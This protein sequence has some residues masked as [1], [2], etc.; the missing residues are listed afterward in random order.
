[1]LGGHPQ[2]ISLAAPM[3][4][5]QNLID[6]FKQLL[7]SNIMDALAYNDKQSYASL[8]ISLDISIRNLERNN[9]EALEL[10]KFIGMLP[11][12]ITQIELTKIWGS[13]EWK[14]HKESLIKASLLVFKPKENTLQ[15]LPFMNTRALEMLDEEGEKKKM[16][17]HLKLCK[18]YKEYLQN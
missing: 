1:M 2:A 6:L 11:G 18:Y 3:L 7:D 4:E 13:D 10:F 8:R 16:K 5:S 12:G 17:F 9:K 14:S 15:L